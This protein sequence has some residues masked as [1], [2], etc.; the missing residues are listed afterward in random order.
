M[1]KSKLMPP[2]LKLKDLDLRKSKLMPPLLLKL[3]DLDL[4]KSKLMPLL[5][6]LLNRSKNARREM[7][8][9]LPQN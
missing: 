1:R 7:L 2:P 4:R 6:K 9:K 3:K 5:L 8:L